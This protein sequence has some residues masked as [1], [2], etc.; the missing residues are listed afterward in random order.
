MSDCGQLALPDD[1]KWSGGPPGCPGGLLGFSG[2][3]KKPSR[4]PGSVWEG[5][6]DVREWSENPPECPEVFR[7]PSRMSGRPS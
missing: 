4:M 3:V 7:R 1:R 6:P 5:L 2:V